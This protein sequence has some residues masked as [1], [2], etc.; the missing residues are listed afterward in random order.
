MKGGGVTKSIRKR[1]EF[2]EGGQNKSK[3]TET[4]PR[5]HKRDLLVIKPIHGASK[6]SNITLKGFSI[7]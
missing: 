1:L 6:V 4:Y 7:E 3:A 2:E 5:D